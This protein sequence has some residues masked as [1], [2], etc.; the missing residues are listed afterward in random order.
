MNNY[1]TLREIVSDVQFLHCDF[2]HISRNTKET[3]IEF[4][5]W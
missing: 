3:G 1:P 2:Y 4:V 5:I